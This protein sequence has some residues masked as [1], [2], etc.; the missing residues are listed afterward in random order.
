M[1]PL[2]LVNFRILVLLSLI[3]LAI[4]SF[5]AFPFLGLLFYFLYCSLWNLWGWAG[6]GHE[7]VHNTFF[8][9]S[10][11]NKFFLVIV[12]LLTL[13][14]Y[15]IFKL[16]HF[17]HHLSPHSNLDLESPYV[18]N[19][20]A[21]PSIVCLEK[22]I[23]FRKLFATMK[24]LVLNSCGVVP[25]D[26]LLRK[27]SRL[28]KVKSIAFNSQIILG[29]IAVVFLASFAFG[30]CVPIVAL[31]LPNFL[32][33]NLYSNLAKLQHPTGVIADFFRL[34]IP[35]TDNLSAS[36]LRDRLDIRLPT[37]LE[38]FY[39]GMNYHASHHYKMSVPGFELRV[40]SN[41][42]VRENIVLS[43]QLSSLGLL[44][45]FVSG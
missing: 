24:Y 22:L 21:N 13:S 2:L 16:T 4:V 34:D 7:L 27:A 19:I 38:F 18:L 33:C 43:V 45:L 29:Y 11:V 15:R 37:F 36:D 32:C 31:L 39:A 6:L 40:L 3:A 42:L 23:N 5:A 30:S 1:L 41:K 26:P 9:K 14:N 28:G 12:S 44:R 10:R 35:A 20:N 17:D 8:K 25:L